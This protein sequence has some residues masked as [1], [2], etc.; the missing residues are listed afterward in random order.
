MHLVDNRVLKLKH[1]YQIV[2]RP[3][4]NKYYKELLYYLSYFISLQ[5]FI[6]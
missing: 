5:L 3:K 2:V 4:A 6:F 1:K